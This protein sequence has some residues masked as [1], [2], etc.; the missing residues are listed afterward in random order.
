ML[1]SSVLVG[2]LLYYEMPRSAE[3]FEFFSSISVLLV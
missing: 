1:F 2:Q 3:N